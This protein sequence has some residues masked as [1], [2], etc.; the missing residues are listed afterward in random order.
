MSKWVYASDDVLTVDLPFPIPDS[1]DVNTQAGSFDVRRYHNNATFCYS[2]RKKLDTRWAD[3]IAVRSPKEQVMSWTLETMSHVI[4]ERREYYNGVAIYQHPTDQWFK[5][6]RVGDFYSLRDATLKE[7][8]KRRFEANWHPN[9]RI[10][11]KKEQIKLYDENQN[12]TKALTTA[13]Q[14]WKEMTRKRRRI[15]KK[16]F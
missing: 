7:F 2:Q 3:K 13:K 6:G 11:K 16:H 14:T 15:I 9:V 5:G 1:A 10:W 8:H 12:K 4:P